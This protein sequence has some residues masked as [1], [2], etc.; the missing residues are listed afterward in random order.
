MFS[1]QKFGG[2]LSRLRKERDMTQSEL[3][4]KLNL[5]R[6]AISK[7]ETGDS[8]PDVSVL[9]NIA[10]IFH[11]TLDELI[12]SGE[13]TVGEAAILSTTARNEPTAIA[14]NIE[15]I[16]GIAPLLKPSVLERASVGLARRGIDVTHIVEL[17]EFLNDKTVIAMLEN[18]TDVEASDE[19]VSRL[20]PFMDEKAR[21]N[22]FEKILDGEMDWHLIKIL[23]P[24]A[25]YL[26]S[27]LEAAVMEG[28]LPWEALEMLREGLKEIHRKW[29][30]ERDS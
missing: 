25:E 9:V 24:Y 11:V 5:T 29:I 3:A 23:L 19:L 15:D 13:P 17:S 30:A 22:V 1:T 26:S 6:Q 14:Q 28:A 7:Y 18:A 4:D 27:P 20:I 2:Y 21:Y 16:R 10:N 8:F 12:R